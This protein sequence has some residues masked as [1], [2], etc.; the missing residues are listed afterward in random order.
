MVKWHRELQQA[1]SLQIFLIL[2][3]T[4]FTWSVLEYFFPNERELMSIS[5]CILDKLI[6]NFELSVF[7]FLCIYVFMSSIS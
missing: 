4:D 5:Y 2:S 7:I 3:S 1:I 6:V